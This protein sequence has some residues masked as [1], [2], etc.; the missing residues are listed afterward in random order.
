[1]KKV[2]L[3]ALILFLILSVLT[4]CKKT[5]DSPIVIGKDNNKMIENAQKDETENSDM[6]LA[7][8]YG[9]PEEYKFDNTGNDG[10]LTV[11]AAA[12]I[13]VPDVTKMPIINVKSAVF[14]QDTVDHFW[15]AL[16]GDEQMWEWSEQ[17]TKSDVEQMIV[18]QNQFIAEADKEGKA[19]ELKSLKERLSY[20]E[21]MYQTAPDTQDIQPASPQLKEKVEW[22]PVTGE[23][24]TRYMGTQGC[25]AKNNAET[26]DGRPYKWFRVRNPWI[27]VEGNI[28]SNVLPAQITFNTQAI[29]NN[30][31]FGGG[32]PISENEELDDNIKALLKLTPQEAKAKVEAFLKQTGTPM[33]IYTISIIRDGMKLDGTMETPKHY[34][35]FIQC[36]RTVEGIPVGGEGSTMESEATY[37]KPWYYESMSFL[38]DDVG[39]ID[40][41]WSAPLEVLDTEVEDSQL[42]PF[43]E[44]QSVFEKMVFISTEASIQ[45]GNRMEFN[46]TKVCL[47]LMRVIK[48][49]SDLEGLL[50]PVWNFY[51]T[52]SEYDENNSPLPTKGID[53]ILISINAI[54]GSIIDTGRGY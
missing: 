37:N 52:R 4:G 9:I 25:T 35:Y 46:V 50:I 7:E 23:I 16:I 14:S 10:K 18:R 44:I 39:F 20:F 15:S 27:G 42:L 54:D 2:L 31:I 21:K 22:D 26:N 51:G 40:I 11:R 6:S 32:T 24:D 12:P 29:S 49:N 38:L 53:F 8:Q 1:M 36:K 45:D 47:E 30:Y 34:A 17:P 28:K 5:P 33:A 3:F 19:D 41:L 13:F 43:N 48:Q